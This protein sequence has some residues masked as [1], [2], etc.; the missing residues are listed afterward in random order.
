MIEELEK[1]K[2]DNENLN[3][4]LK[5]LQEQYEE[6][7]DKYDLLET[8]YSDNIVIQ[9]MNDMKVKYDNMIKNTIPSYRYNALLNKYNTLLK[10]NSGS[11]VLLEHVLKMLKKIENNIMY[12]KNILFKAELELLT[13]KDILEDIN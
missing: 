2:I 8:Q 10:N 6:L 4:E 9:S 5:V 12:D 7:L 11:V 1:I 13:I 3:K